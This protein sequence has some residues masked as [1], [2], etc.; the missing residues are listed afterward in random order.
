MR[1]VIPNDIYRG[2]PC[3][4]V[5]VGCALGVADLG[6]LAG[7][8]SPDLELDGYLSLKSMNTLIRANLRVK[9]AESY[10]RGERPT[11]GAW[12]HDHVGDEAIICVHGH[13]LYF[14]GYDYYSF[15][16]N[17]KDPV[18]KVWYLDRD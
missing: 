13:F 8:Q 11:L 12:A 9:K 17:G 18:V 6:A 4:I 2:L 5:A 15:F 3:S 16:L 1:R 10:K 7:L 14:D